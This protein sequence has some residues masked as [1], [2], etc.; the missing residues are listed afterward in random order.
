[1][2]PTD[3]SGLSDNSVESEVALMSWMEETRSVAVL[4]DGGYLV[5]GSNNILTARL[6]PM[7]G[8]AVERRIWIQAIGEHRQLVER[9]FKLVEDWRGVG[10]A[11]DGPLYRHGIRLQSIC[12]IVV[13]WLVDWML[14][15]EFLSL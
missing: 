11:I 1:M 10:G 7:S 3:E 9:F 15:N 14:E 4:A 12:I 13:Y 5:D 2:V 8:N 6:V